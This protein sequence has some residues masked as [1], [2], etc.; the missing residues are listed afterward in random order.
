MNFVVQYETL[1]V[2]LRQ[3]KKSSHIIVGYHL[4]KY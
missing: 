4:S 1:R 3:G 2:V